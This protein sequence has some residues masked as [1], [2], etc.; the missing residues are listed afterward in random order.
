[1]KQKLV[2]LVV[3]TL[4]FASSVVR[5]ADRYVTTNGTG[6]G[7]SWAE[8]ANLYVGVTGATNCTVWVSNGVYQLTSQITVT[9]FTIKSF[10]ANGAVDR[11][12]TIIDGN[13]YAGKAVTNRCFTLSHSNAVVEG[14]TITNGYV[15]AL[16]GGGVYMTAGTL[17]NCLVTGN[18]STN[19]NGGGV[20]AAGATCVISNCDLFFNASYGVG[21][22]AWLTTSA[23]LKNSRVYFNRGLIA[24]SYG[25][26]VYLQTGALLYGCEIVSNSLPNVSSTYGGG[27]CINSANATVRNCLIVGN[28]ANHGAGV[29]C[30][31]FG[32]VVESCTIFGNTGYAG[33]GVDTTWHAQTVH[34]RNTICRNQVVSYA[35]GATFYITNSC[36]ASTNIVKSFGSGNF[37]ND[38][39]FVN[40]AVLDLRLTSSSPCINTGTNQVWMTGALDL[41]GAPRLDWRDGLVDMGAYEYVPLR[42]SGTLMM[43]R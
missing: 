43:I 11:N 16:G 2:A 9:N 3:L 19:A 40:S 30:M 15:T 39:K 38:P 5:A 35:D 8:P 27:V 33:Q 25:G 6:S 17:R 13:N 42:P 12:G 41:V 28:V 23:Q 10:G 24:A 20:Y 7:A 34:I 22:G 31:Q 29:G 18:G 36:L 26:G 37:T 4:C 14:L 32:G 21:A 1:M